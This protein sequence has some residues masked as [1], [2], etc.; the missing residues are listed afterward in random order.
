MSRA[1]RM[2]LSAISPMILLLCSCGGA[3]PEKREDLNSANILSGTDL[4][5]GAKAVIERVYTGGATGDTLHKAWIC[6][7]GLSNCELSAIIDTQD[8]P[9][10]VWRSSPKMLDLMIAPTDVV[11]DFSNFSYLPGPSHRT[12]KVRLVERLV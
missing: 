12:I 11:W 9:P 4:A 6:Q 8:G 1:E 10:P 2:S 5:G 3:V 7:A